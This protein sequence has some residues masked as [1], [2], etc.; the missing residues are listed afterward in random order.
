MESTPTTKVEE[1]PMLLFLGFLRRPDHHLL[2]L[3]AMPSKRRLPLTNSLLLSSVLTPMMLFTT[4]LTLNFPTLRRRF[5]SFTTLM[6]PVL[7]SSELSNH[8]LFSSDN[9]KR[10]LLSTLELLTKILFLTSSSHSW[11]QLF[12]L[13]LD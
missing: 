11:S 6:P 2:R 3:P 8:N 13:S 5:L 12:S 10:N 4:R 1:L 7:P 9:S